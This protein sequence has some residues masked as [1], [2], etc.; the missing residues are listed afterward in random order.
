MMRSELDPQSVQGSG[1][2]NLFGHCDCWIVKVAT[3]DRACFLCLLY[4]IT[5]LG[6]FLNIYSLFSKNIFL[7]A[8]KYTESDRRIET[9]SL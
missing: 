7:Y 2:P 5:L 4:L 8:E 6:H 3:F 9:N 1:H